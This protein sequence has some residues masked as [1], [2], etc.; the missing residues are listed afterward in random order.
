MSR[1][2]REIDMKVIKLSDYFDKPKVKPVN[3]AE[4]DERLRRIRINLNKLNGLMSELKRMSDD[5]DHKVAER[6]ENNER[7]LCSIKRA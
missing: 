4:F 3:S 5:S 1:S 7:I 6:K 2:N